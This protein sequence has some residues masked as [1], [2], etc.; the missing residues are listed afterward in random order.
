MGQWE[1]T[2]EEAASGVFSVRSPNLKNDLFER[3]TSSITLQVD[4][5]WGAGVLHYSQYASTQQP[6]DDLKVFVDGRQRDGGPNRLDSTSFEDRNITLS[7]ESRNIS[8]VYEYNPNSI[9]VIGAPPEQD[10]RI[11]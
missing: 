11:A 9:P 6:F 3:R 7:P 4:P 8:W 1:R 10:E 2:S 5:E